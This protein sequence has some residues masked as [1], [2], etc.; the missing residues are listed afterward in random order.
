MNQ[1]LLCCGVLLLAAATGLAGAAPLWGP[2]GHDITALVATALLDSTAT[3]AVNSILNGASLESVA[4]WA[5]QIK[6]KPG[7]QWSY[8]LHFINTPSW[9]CHFVHSR[10]CGDDV[11]VA[12][13]IQNYTQ[14]VG[15]E[16][17]EQQ[18]IALK[19]LTHFVGDIHQPLHC[20]F[21]A[22]KGGN[23]IQGTFNGYADNLHEIWDTWVIKERMSNDFG[24][25]HTAYA[26]FLVHQ[27]QGAWAANATR[28]AACGS[29]ECA[30]AWGNES[31]GLA[32]EYAY[33]DN[34][35]A[36]IESGFDLGEPYYRYAY[37][38][39]DMQLAKG[40]VRLAT[41]L[42]NVIGAGRA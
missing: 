38:V 25:D 7:W 26:N 3:S 32:C 41:V 37:P 30:D 9:N 35:G 5:D 24:S 16:S 14:R 36:K 1:A 8:D 4:N 31:T 22:D 39:I 12:G 11:C 40:G 6:N 28:W 42:N 27:V 20:G 2:D 15:S 33:R 23:T 34:T 10:D 19:F 17:G 18:T 29:N 13:A 21:A